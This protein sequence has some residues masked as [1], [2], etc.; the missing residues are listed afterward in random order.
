MSDDFRDKTCGECAWESNGHCRRVMWGAIPQYALGQDGA[1][2]DPGYFGSVYT[3][4]PACPA[5]VPKEKPD[6]PD[7]PTCP[8]CGTTRQPN[9]V[10]VSLYPS[11][12]L[13]ECACCGHKSKAFV[14]SQR[15]LEDFY[16]P[17]PKETNHE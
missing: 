2:S 13:V 6:E 7:D 1:W 12:Y 4:M 5:F 3:N 8:A 11:R 17:L 14:N 10:A 9:W 16:K 15:A